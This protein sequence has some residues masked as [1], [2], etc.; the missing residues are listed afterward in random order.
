VKERK[1]ESTKEFRKEEVQRRMKE[2][3]KRKGKV[4]EDLLVHELTVGRSRK[5]SV[6]GHRGTKI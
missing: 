4:E 6:L 1:T 5:R 2:A 3:Q